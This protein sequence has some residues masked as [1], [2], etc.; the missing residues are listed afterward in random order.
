MAK[1]LNPRNDIAFKRIFGTEKNKDILMHFLNDVIAVNGKPL[2]KEVTLL[3]PMQQPEIASKK[4]SIVDVLCEDESGIKYIVEM[5]VAKV[6][7]FEKRAQFYAAKAYASQPEKGETYDHLKEVIFLAITEYEMFPKKKS[8]KCEH[9]LM[10]K[11]TGE[12]DLKD[13]SFTFLE[14]P[15]FKKNIEELKT[16]EDKWLFFFKHANEPD[17]VSN[18]LKNSSEVIQKAYHELEAHNWTEKE[19][20]AYEDSEKTAKDNK[21]REV[22]VKEAGKA[23]GL[24]EGIEKGKAEGLA[25]GKAA[26]VKNM[27]AKAISKSDISSMTGILIA[28]INKIAEEK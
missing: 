11:E 21:A 7:G 8:Y 20:L 23:E 5:Q 25:E 24:A 15:K 12:R 26:V 19:L 13:F 10:D 14:L 27:L 17:D 22:F 28:D 2:I 18:L 16:Y 4:Q 1:Y 3:N 6:A 9:W